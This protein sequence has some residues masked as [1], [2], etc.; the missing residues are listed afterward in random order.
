[1]YLLINTYFLSGAWDIYSC[2]LLAIN[3]FVLMS[4]VFICS[5]QVS[6][7]GG[8]LF[9]KLY[10]CVIVLCPILSLSSTI[11]DF[12]FTSCFCGFM[13]S[14]SSCNLLFIFSVHILFEDTR[15]FFCVWACSEVYWDVYH[16]NVCYIFSLFV[17][18]F[19]RVYVRRCLMFLN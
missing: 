12:L 9:S 14:F 16:F 13:S 11:C 5:F 4:N 17:H 2:L 7:T 15:V 10:L 19:I 3:F 6:Q 1:M 8:L 18:L